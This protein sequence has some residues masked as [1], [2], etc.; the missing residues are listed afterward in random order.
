MSETSKKNQEMINLILDNKI[1]SIQ[2]AKNALNIPIQL[3]VTLDTFKKQLK[4]TE[5]YLERTQVEAKVDEDE[6]YF[7]TDAQFFFINNLF[8]NLSGLFDS[9]LLLVTL[10]NIS[11]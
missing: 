4:L 6:T 2:D 5:Q 9:N 10:F 3:V 11:E 8:V 7:L 1:K